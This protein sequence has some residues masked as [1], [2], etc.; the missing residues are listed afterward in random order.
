MQIQV[1]IEINVEKFM[2]N[3][4]FKKYLLEFLNQGQHVSGKL[5]VRKKLI[6]DISEWKMYFIKG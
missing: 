6:C 3:T 5:C 2:A 1:Q 4:I